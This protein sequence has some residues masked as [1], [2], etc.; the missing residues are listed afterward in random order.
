MVT[1]T[2][3]EPTLRAD[4]GE[5]VGHAKRFVTRLN[6]NGVALTKELVDELK[7]ASLDSLQVTLYSHDERVHNEL[8]GAERFRDTVNGIRRA[9]SAGLDV[10]INTPLCKKNSDYVKTLEFIKS[11][12]VK[13]VTSSGLIC[14]GM[15]EDSH[16][17]YDLDSE[18]LYG[19]I[20]EAKAFCDQ[21]N[22]EIDFTSPG[23]ISKERLES[24][25]M[26]VP[27]CGAALSN[28]AIAPDGTVVPCQSWLT[29]DSSL[30]NILNGK[31]K[32]IWN[33]KLAK[34]LRIM[35]EDEALACPFRNNLFKG[36]KL[37]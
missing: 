8:V 21:N 33:S 4:I 16:S 26:K 34:S 18:E 37:K 12:G 15:A 9:V 28:M 3:G 29:S 36:G 20:S 32:K 23:L 17:E 11:L 13:F 35:T 19:V 7:K 1:F 30:G 25:K 14:T 24:L 27:A 6:T 22:M 31:W 10:S 2:G 5:L